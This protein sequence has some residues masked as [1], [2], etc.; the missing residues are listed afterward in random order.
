MQLA[1]GLQDID[2]THADYH[3]VGS[4]LRINYKTATSNNTSKLAECLLTIP[5]TDIFTMFPAI[6]SIIKEVQN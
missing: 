2:L 3:G 1:Q 5:V 6:V 4:V